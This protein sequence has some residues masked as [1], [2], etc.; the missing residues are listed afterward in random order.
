MILN[1]DYLTRC[2][3]TLKQSLILLNQSKPNSLEYEIFR[4]AIVKGFELTK[5]ML[6]G[7]K[8]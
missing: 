7:A 5:D 6:D 1:T 3:E 2:I 4:N 8:A